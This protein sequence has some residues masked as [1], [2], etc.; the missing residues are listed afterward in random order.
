MNSLLSAFSSLNVDI[1]RHDMMVICECY[2]AMLPGLDKS[3][4][5]IKKNTFPDVTYLYR[6]ILSVL[7]DLHKSEYLMD[8][9]PYIDDYLEYYECL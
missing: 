1:L 4:L 7:S 6:E 9:M 8:L 5:L 2:A 3:R